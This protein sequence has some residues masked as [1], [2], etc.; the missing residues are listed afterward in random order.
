MNVYF[1]IWFAQ[2]NSIGWIFL[3]LSERSFGFY[4]P[5]QVRTFGWYQPSSFKYFFMQTSIL[6]YIID[7]LIYTWPLTYESLHFLYSQDL[8]FF[9]VHWN[10]WGKKSLQRKLLTSNPRS[11]DIL[12][13]QVGTVNT[14]YSIFIWLWI[15]DKTFQRYNRCDKNSIYAWFISVRSC[16]ISIHDE[17]KCKQT[18]DEVGIRYILI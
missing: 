17:K 9:Q 12:E 10:S 4:R 15:D 11:V 13:W 2:V 16:N 7:N 3:L 1:C 14:R 5:T 6:C 18:R 8:I